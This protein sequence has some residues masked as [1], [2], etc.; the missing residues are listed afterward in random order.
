MPLDP[1]SR[2]RGPSLYA[3][4]AAA[5]VASSAYDYGSGSPPDSPRG[6]RRSARPAVT[7]PDGGGGALRP[8]LTADRSTPLTADRSNPLTAARSTAAAAMLVMPVIPRPRARRVRRSAPLRLDSSFCRLR[9]GRHH[10]LTGGALF[11]PGAHGSV[12]RRRRRSTDVLVSRHRLV[13]ARVIVDVAA[14]AS[15]GCSRGGGRRHDGAV[16]SAIG[17]VGR[18]LG[19]LLT[20]RF[21]RCVFV[22]SGSSRQRRRGNLCDEKGRQ[23]GRGG[24]GAMREGRRCVSVWGGYLWREGRSVGST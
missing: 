9:R 1:R 7:S 18:G 12:P 6:R 10:A 22:N 24:G 2:G 5:A 8:P 23:R 3:A 15:L 13:A 14:R 11:D 16:R 4:A 17:G 21:A 20:G 19:S